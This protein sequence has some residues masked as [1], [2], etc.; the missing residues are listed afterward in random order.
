MYR[1][2]C[3]EPS[4]RQGCAAGSRRRCETTGMP[5]PVGVQPY[6]RL[7][8]APGRI[9]RCELQQDSQMLAGNPPSWMFTLLTLS[10]RRWQTICRRGGHRSR[11]RPYKTPALRVVRRNVRVD[12]C[13]G[14]VPGGGR[15]RLL[16]CLKWA[17]GS[18]RGSRNRWRW[19]GSK[20]T[21]AA[22]AS[23]PTH[24]VFDLKV[25]GL[26]QRPRCEEPSMALLHVAEV[27][28]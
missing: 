3:Y 16:H 8:D 15:Y 28:F 26:A 1:E 17:F 7:F 18:S 4:G 19:A 23:G 27:H 12:R 13:F 6:S 24:R 14:R 21:T 25:S 10:S 5:G 9:V 2:L 22:L 20:L 11:R